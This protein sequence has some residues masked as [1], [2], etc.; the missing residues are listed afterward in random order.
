MS[1]SGS[2]CGGS[3]SGTIGDSNP[4]HLTSMLQGEVINS[5]NGATIADAI[6]ILENG[7]KEYV[8]K[9]DGR[10]I[11][12]ID[13]VEVGSYRLT[14][15]KGG[16]RT[17]NQSITISQ[18]MNQYSAIILEPYI[19]TG[20]LNGTVV[21]YTSSS[22]TPLPLFEVEVNF[23]AL[24]KSYL[25]DVNG[26]FSAPDLPA[27]M[28]VF[29]L[30]LAGYREQRVLVDITAD[31][32]SDRTF[33]MLDLSG[34]LK[35][36]VKGAPSMNPLTGILV[37]IDNLSITTV[38]NSSGCY[39]FDGVTSGI[40]PVEFEADSYTSSEIV[41]TITEGRTTTL[42][43]TMNYGFGTIFGTVKDNITGGVVAGVTISMPVSGLTSTTN[44]SGD[45]GFFNIV[46]T[47]S[48][49]PVGSEH[50]SYISSGTYVSLDPGQIRNVDFIIQ[51]KSGSLKG[52]VK[53]TGAGVP[54]VG[55]SLTISPLGIST[56]SD[57][58]GGY[59][60]NGVLPGFTPVTV[61][62]VGYQTITTSVA[63]TAGTTTFFDIAV[64]S[65]P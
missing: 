7:F 65:A 32:V 50:S 2:G 48:F 51:P 40:W 33:E 28:N 39:A 16:F 4:P 46:R 1:F 57:S 59:F 61:S 13:N 36:C 31:T 29:V 56:I 42:D 18:G 24:S 37:S 10:G 45:Y 53:T 41:T 23:P 8:V 58:G 22:A 5:S 19:S 25:T 21:R 35:G 12:E 3:G 43:V 27:G 9:T 63:T 30:T 34:K 17:S 44:I 52:I 6:L 14:A 11:Y 38:T 55:A 49:I 26:K 54:I 60:F 64:P 15:G 62:A 47:G 20:T